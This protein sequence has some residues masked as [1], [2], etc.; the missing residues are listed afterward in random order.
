[1]AIRSG[2]LAELEEGASFDVIVCEGAVHKTPQAW[3]GAIAQGGRMGV[4]ERNGP[5]GKARL[6]MRGVDRVAATRE[7]FDANA[8]TLPGFVA[9]PAFVF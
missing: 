4:V 9:P 1:M 7:L 2:A 3:I 6:Y 5:V 8:P